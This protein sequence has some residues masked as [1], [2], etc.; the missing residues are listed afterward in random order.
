MASRDS[1]TSDPA[2]ASGWYAVLPE[3]P[4]AERLKGELTADWVVVGAGFTGLAAARRLAEM[5]PEARVILVEQHRFG[6]GTSGRNSG[7]IIDA[8]CYTPTHDADYN[9]RMMR[10]IRAGYAALKGL[11]QRHEIP[12][13]WSEVGHLCAVAAPQRATLLEDVCRSLDA[14]GDDYEWLEASALEALIGT[15]YYHAAIRLPRTILMNPSALCRGLGETLPPN[16]EVYEETPV[17]GIAAGETVRIDCA[18]GSIKAKNLLLATNAF[19]P[20]LGYLKRQL[21]PM[22]LYASLSKPLSAAQQAAM[23]G[24][25]EWGLTPKVAMGSTIR[26]VGN[27]MMIRNRA[28][29]TSDFRIDGALKASLRQTHRELL[30]KRFPMLAD[31]EMEHSWG[32]VIAMTENYSAVFGRLEPGL[33]AAMGYNG[34]GIARGA[35]SGAALAEYAMAGE[36]GIIDDVMGLAGPSRFPPRPFLD[37]GVMATLAWKRL[38]VG[39][40]R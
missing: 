13:D 34:V 2:Q 28:R 18:E 24:L 39:I 40:D 25:P 10:I 38:W 14:V 4:Q 35:A 9:R 19:T 7:F 27:R 31:L 16:V 21:M 6:Y 8:P 12:C 30:T 26:R 32:G 37:L 29:L 11:I 17:T 15:P 5:A 1:P 22:L 33:F 36:S 23:S 20:A 3:P